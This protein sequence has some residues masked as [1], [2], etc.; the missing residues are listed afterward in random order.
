MPRIN[1]S[2]HKRFSEPRRDQPLNR[3]DDQWKPGQGA[4]TMEGFFYF[5]ART[6]T[7]PQITPP[8]PA[9]SHTPLILGYNVAHVTISNINSL[10]D[11]RRFPAVLIFS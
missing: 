2:K 10:R 11:R 4:P 3:M 8:L 6:P 9:P 7:R 1:G 5:P